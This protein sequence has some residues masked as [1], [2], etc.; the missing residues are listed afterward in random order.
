MVYFL[1]KETPSYH[2]KNIFSM[3]QGRVA[4]D[5]PPGKKFL[6]GWGRF[7]GPNVY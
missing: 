3:D 6:L 4:L 5:S 2:K 7:Q 1:K